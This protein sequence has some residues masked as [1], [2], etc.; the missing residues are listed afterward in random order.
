MPLSNWLRGLYPNRQAFYTTPVSR[1]GFLAR[2][3]TPRWPG[4]LVSTYA[5]IPVVVPP[6]TLVISGGADCICVMSTTAPASYAH[7]VPTRGTTA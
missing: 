5:H 1:K 2:D 7:F 4:V 6:P 3:Q